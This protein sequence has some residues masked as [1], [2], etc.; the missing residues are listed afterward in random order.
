MIHH[1]GGYGCA[2]SVE[3][4]DPTF[5]GGQTL[6]LA[7][8]VTD[9]ESPGL[10][11]FLRALSKVLG[12]KPFLDAL[13]NLSDSATVQEIAKMAYTSWKAPAS[14]RKDAAGCG[15]GTQV[16]QPGICGRSTPDWDS[17]DA[18]GG[19]DGEGD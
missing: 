2:I 3:I 9:S 17:D 19:K 1:E 8:A 11:A 12:F 6:A 10:G 18:Q 7:K 13:T 14:L 4:G 16:V 5:I 15:P